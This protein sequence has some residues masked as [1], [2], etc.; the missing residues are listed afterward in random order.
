MPRIKHRKIEPD[1]MARLRDEGWSTAHIAAQANLAP[2]TVRTYLSKYSTPKMYQVSERG[3]PVWASA[4]PERGA[5]GVML[6][7]Q[8]PKAS[9]R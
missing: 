6:P 4:W 8:L 3:E 1:D 9:C 2:S 5:E 7:H